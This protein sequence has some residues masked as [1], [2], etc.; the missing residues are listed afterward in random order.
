MLA[1]GNIG[2]QGG[3]LTVQGWL[4]DVKNAQSPQVLGKQYREK[5]NED[6]ARAHRAPLRR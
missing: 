5:A 6:N 4:Y 3:S 1:F 2:V